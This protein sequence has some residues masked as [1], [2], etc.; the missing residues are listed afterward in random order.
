M[1]EGKID[2]VFE[3][4]RQQMQKQFG[5]IVTL[6]EAS[7]SQGA[8][9]QMTKQM[10]I[11]RQGPLGQFARSDVEAQRILEGFKARESGKVDEKG[12]ADDI[13]QSSMDKGTALQ[14]KSYTAVNQILGHVSAI[15]KAADV[16]TLKFMQQG[17]TAGQGSPMEDKLSKYQKANMANL[18]AGMTGATVMDSDELA[19]SYAGTMKSGELTDTLGRS[20][21]GAIKGFKSFVK[22]AGDAIMAPMDALKDAIGMG[23]TK[24]AIDRIKIL[25]DD[26][27]KRKADMSKLS[28]DKRKEAMDII[29][30]EEGVVKQA[31]AWVQSAEGSPIDLSKTKSDKVMPPGAKVGAAAVKATGTGAGVTPGAPGVTGTP[32]GPGVTPG[33][34]KQDVTVHVT[35]FCLKCK[36]EI[37]NSAQAN[38]VAPQAK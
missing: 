31:T 17:M 13:V 30:K 1:R 10:M 4:V 5:R 29:A 25:Q 35:G 7:Q 12:L 22:N 18:K 24:A 9:A 32:G 20:A 28:V 37:D 27:K 14:E 8:A 16:G 38:A 26:I 23:D 3:K 2:Q 19:A 33:M 6:D 21:A 34:F 11:L 15:R 36:Q